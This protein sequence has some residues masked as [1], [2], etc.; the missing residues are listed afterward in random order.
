[1]ER[2]LK[3]CNSSIVRNE[4]LTKGAIHRFPG[5]RMPIVSPC[6]GTQVARGESIGG[7]AFFG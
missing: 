5:E 7:D 3:Q 1:M 4:R 2:R 6:P